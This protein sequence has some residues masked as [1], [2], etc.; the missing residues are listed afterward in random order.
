[1]ANNFIDVS[2][3]SFKDTYGSYDNYLLQCLNTNSDISSSDF[4]VKKVSGGFASSSL[5]FLRDTWQTK[6]IVTAFHIPDKSGAIH[7][8]DLH[9]VKFVR[10]RKSDLWIKNE[11][12]DIREEEVGKLLTFINQQNKLI[13]KKLDNAYYR[14]FSADSPT[15]LKDLDIAID[16]I[17]KNKEIDFKQLDQEGSER[18]LQ[19]VKKILEGENVLLEKGLYQQL[20]TSRS[21]Q[22]TINSYRQDLADFNELLKS[23][24]TSET[25][26]QNFLENRLWFFGLNYI[27]SHRNSKSKFQSSLGTEYDFLLEGFNQVYDIA[28]LKSPNNLLFDVE[29][30]SERER[31]LNNR[32]DYKFSSKF[33]RALHQVMSYMDEFEENFG[34]IKTNQP[35]LKNFMYPKG[36]IIISKRSL[37]PDSGKNSIKYLHL[38]NRQFSNIDVLTYDDLA[39]RGQIAIDFLEKINEQI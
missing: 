23:D 27:Q 26:M 6:F 32:V 15:T 30:T 35:D 16:L 3:P 13:G 11:V 19:L 21:D 12:C 14:I 2:L 37:F 33:S 28:E 4:D 18:V 20:I 1:M 36:T 34:H 38:I 9:L 31:A 8:Y 5:F 22:K 17:L 10:K 39:D 24:S 25:D 29:R 7:H